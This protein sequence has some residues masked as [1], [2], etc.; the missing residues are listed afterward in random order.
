MEFF[1]L[2][3]CELRHSVLSVCFCAPTLRNAFRLFLKPIYL[4]LEGVRPVFPESA[5]LALPGEQPPSQ[6]C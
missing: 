2:S 5:K 4:Y 6:L 3:C 1:R